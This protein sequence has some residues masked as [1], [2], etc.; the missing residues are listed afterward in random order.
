[1]KRRVIAVIVFALAAAACDEAP[2]DPDGQ[3]SEFFLRANVEGAWE[4]ESF[5]AASASIGS[6]T[7]SGYESAGT[8]PYILSISLYNIGGPGTYP[9]GTGSTVAG[10]SVVVSALNGAWS[11]PLSGADGSITITTLN[12][13]R[14]AGTFNFALSA[15]S[16]SASGTKTGT[17]GEFSLEL[18]PPA[19]ATP[20]PDNYGSKVSATFAG[21]PWNAANASG[22]Y[23][24][25]NRVLS[26][27]ASNNGRTMTIAVN[28]VT[29]P[30]TFVLS[31]T[32]RS[33]SVSATTNTLSNTWNSAGT[34]GSGSVTVTSITA[35]RMRG[36][37][38]ATLGPTLG[39]TT[40]GT[41]AVASGSFDIGLGAP[42]P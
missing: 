14:I 4:A 26:V 35:T 17:N 3:P 13:T 40:T 33:M 15:L 31:G 19:S 1:M 5:Y 12:T 36:A 29:G 27:Q 32:A 2:T 25:A 41:L 24:A 9:L 37:F 20:L 42:L 16:G 7:L 34:G 38:T 11:S 39:S 6:Y 10:G 23:S 30:G 22:S 28:E 8:N 18:T 21:T